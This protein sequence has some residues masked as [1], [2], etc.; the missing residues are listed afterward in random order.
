MQYSAALCQT[1]ERH[2]QKNNFQLP[3]KDV[4]H[5]DNVKNYPARAFFTTILPVVPFFLMHLSTQPAIAVDVSSE[6]YSLQTIP[7]SQA[8]AFQTLPREDA[9]QI[10]SLLVP[11]PTR[12]KIQDLKGLQD[13]RLDSCADRGV[14]WEQC[15]MFGDTSVE[16]RDTTTA[17]RNVNAQQGVSTTNRK[18]PT[19]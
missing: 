9:R 13:A 12:K 1:N 8:Q 6:Q 3:F 4:F 5:E 7:L 10:R 16:S 14:Y 17:G 2:D 19:W 15:F 18:P 11:S